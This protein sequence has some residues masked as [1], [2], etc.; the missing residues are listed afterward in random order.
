MTTPDYT[1]KM[2]DLRVIVGQHAKLMSK[3]DKKASNITSVIHVINTQSP[4]FYIIPPVVLIILFMFIKPGFLCEDY[5][6]KDN[7][8]TRKINIKNLIIAGLIGG[9]AISIGL[10]AFFRQKNLK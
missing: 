4:I 3:S 1:Q 8:I 7:V 9:G 5:I 6:D 2:S 10:F